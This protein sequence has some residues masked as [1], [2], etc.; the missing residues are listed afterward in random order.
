MGQ[1]QDVG[2][3]DVRTCDE[4]FYFPFRSPAQLITL[5]G[6]QPFEQ[7][8]VQFLANE[9]EPTGVA[10]V[11]GG[12]ELGVELVGEIGAGDGVVV[13]AEDGGQVVEEVGPE[14]GGQ[15]VEEFGGELIEEDVS[16]GERNPVWSTD[17]IV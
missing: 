4:R 2:C 1:G 12:V 5:H 15:V 7:Q 17:E 3:P 11:E 8:L 10:E 13:G 6:G 16:T 9:E 14:D